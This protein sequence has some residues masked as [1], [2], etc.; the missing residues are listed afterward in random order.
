MVLKII[1]NISI[2]NTIY[3]FKQLGKLVIYNY[4]YI[5]M[6]RNVINGAIRCA[7]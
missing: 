1:M 7:G 5:T 3:I 6:A 4:L 2:Y